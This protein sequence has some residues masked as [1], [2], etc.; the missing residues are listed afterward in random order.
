VQGCASGRRYIV[1]RS[2]RPPA[3]NSAASIILVNN[4]AHRASFKSIEDISDE[5]WELTFRVNIHACST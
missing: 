5:E 1:A 4:A 3:K 2:S